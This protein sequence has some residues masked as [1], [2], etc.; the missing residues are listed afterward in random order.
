MNSVQKQY[1]QIET[2]AQQESAYQFQPWQMLHATFTAGK[3][4]R[5]HV[6]TPQQTSRS[7]TLFLTA[8]WEVFYVCRASQKLQKNLLTIQGCILHL[9]SLQNT[10]S[11]SLQG[12]KFCTFFSQSGKCLSFPQCYEHLPWASFASYF[13][14]VLNFCNLSSAFCFLISI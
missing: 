12:W 13:L 10:C 7:N 1:Q 8:L 6:T 3:Q 5:C 4:E 14:S 2:A 9:S 11:K